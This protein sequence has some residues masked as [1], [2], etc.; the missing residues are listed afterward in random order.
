MKTLGINIPLHYL[1]WILQPFKKLTAQ[2]VNGAIG[3]QIPTHKEQQFISPLHMR[4]N[5]SI[6]ITVSDTDL[7]YLDP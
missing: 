3:R 6:H 2:I 1:T 5:I 4:N 7:V